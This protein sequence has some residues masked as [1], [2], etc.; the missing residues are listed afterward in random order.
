MTR[1]EK[2]VAGLR[3]LGFVPGV[4]APGQR[5]QEWVRFETQSVAMLDDIGTLRV[6]RV[7][8][9]AEPEVIWSIIQAG[10]MAAERTRK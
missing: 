3:A 7:P 6:G 10:V 2:L 1:R 5:W 9:D 4:Q 8:R